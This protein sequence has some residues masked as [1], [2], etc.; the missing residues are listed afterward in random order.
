[1]ED[2]NSILTD[3]C[4]LSMSFEIVVFLVLLEIM[5]TIKIGNVTHQT[6]FATSET[7]AKSPETYGSLFSAF[8]SLGLTFPCSGS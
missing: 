5:K 2:M 3:I 4:A 1:M 8:S 6:T 7:L